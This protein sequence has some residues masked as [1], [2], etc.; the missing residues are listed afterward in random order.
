MVMRHATPAAVLDF[1]FVNARE[2]VAAHAARNAVW[3]GGGPAF[4]SSVRARCATALERAAAGALKHW[5]LSPAGTLALILLFDQVPRNI[6]RATPQAFAFDLRALALARDGVAMAI[7]RELTVAERM[8]FYLPFEH[9]E[10]RAAQVKSVACFERL[11]AEAGAAFKP[12]TA[13]ALQHA[14]THYELIERFGRFPHRNLILDRRSRTD[15]TAWLAAHVQ[16]FGQ[17]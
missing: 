15:E 1:W 13:T 5:Q 16:P 14:R 12:L 9:A 8:F 4:D 11:H 7:D 17:A 2:D 6:F 10:D 3:Y